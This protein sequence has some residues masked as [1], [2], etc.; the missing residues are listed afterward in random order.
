MSNH[1]RKIVVVMAYFN[2]E[3]LVRKTL[4][5]I[6]E[7]A[8]TNYE[9]VIVDDASEQS[10]EDVFCDPGINHIRIPPKIKTWTCPVI[11]YNIGIARAFTYDPDIIV[12]Q[13]A[14][15]YHVGDVL[16]YAND[17]VTE[18]NYVSFACWGDYERTTDT[19]KDIENDDPFRT[20]GG[21]TG[22]YNHPKWRNRAF[23]FCNAYNTETLRDLNGFDERFKDGAGRDDDDLV[24]RLKAAGI[25][26]LF[27]D[28]TQP[29]AVHQWH[30]RDHLNEEMYQRNRVVYDSVVREN[31][32]VRAQHVFTENF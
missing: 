8:H 11:P 15:S 5:T 27:T 17:H 18:D 19:F 13:M 1:C 21:S 2:R 23:H 14:E 3:S 24:R 25:A 30:D 9:I 26:V 7:T 4:E 31:S 22:W 10:I 12:L 28:E 6:Y 20:D 32:G 16:M 29:F